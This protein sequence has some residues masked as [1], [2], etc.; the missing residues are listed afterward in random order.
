M[1]H[2]GPI[3]APICKHCDDVVRF[4][5]K[6]NV[7]LEDQTVGAAGIDKN[8]KG[9][10]V[11][12]V[13]ADLTFRQGAPKIPARITGRIGAQLAFRKLLPVNRL[14]P[15]ERYSGGIQRRSRML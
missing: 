14:E 3:Q 15:R 9:R 10:P 2:A 7:I 5:G 12:E 8:F 1:D 6:P 11:T 13:A 4:K